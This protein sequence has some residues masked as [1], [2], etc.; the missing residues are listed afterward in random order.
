MNSIKIIFFI[1]ISLNI[2]LKVSSNDYL[3]KSL[4]ESNKFIFIR[5]SIAPGSG[6]PINFDIL[7]CS[8]QRNLNYLGINQS[9]KIGQF[10][11]KNNIKIDKVISSQWCRCKETALI[12]FKKFTT[13][14]FLN[15]FYDKKFIKNKDKQINELNEYIKNSKNEGNVVFV[16]HYVVISELLNIFP[17]SGEAIIT[18][19]N[20]NVIDRVIF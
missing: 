20:L 17:N 13:K 4:K 2:S 6:D 8:T 18:D 12:A 1:F 7:D 10:F 3:I 19:K 9:K 14:S 5:H 15:S 11:L 16:T